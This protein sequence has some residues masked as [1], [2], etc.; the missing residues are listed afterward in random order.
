MLE[1]ATEPTIRFYDSQSGAGSDVQVPADIKQHSVADLLK[2]SKLAT[3][4]FLTSAEFQSNYTHF[5]ATI[6]VA[7]ATPE[8]DTLTANRTD[9]QFK[10]RPALS[11]VK[12]TV[13]RV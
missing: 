5:Q 4:G 6:A 13:S 12:V 9:I 3:V 1:T 10:S 7:D 11:Q 2:G 8:V